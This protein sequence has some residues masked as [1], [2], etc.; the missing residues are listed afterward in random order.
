MTA[1]YL[2]EMTYSAYLLNFLSSG[3]YS[4]PYLAPLKEMHPILRPRHRLSPLS[5]YFLSP[6]INCQYNTALIFVLKLWKLP[7]AE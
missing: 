2:E 3:Y 4:S 7:Y 1:A 5:L 6:S